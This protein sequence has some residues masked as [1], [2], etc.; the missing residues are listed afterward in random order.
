MDDNGSTITDTSGNNRNGTI[1]NAQRIPLGDKTLNFNLG[2]DSSDEKSVTL[3]DISTYSLGIDNLDIT[4]ENSLASLD[5]AIDNVSKIEAGYGANINTLQ[6]SLDNDS[7]QEIQTE[8]SNQRIEDAD[9]SKESSE[10]TKEEIK[11]S[12]TILM[13][14]KNETNRQQILSLLQG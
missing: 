4:Q 9:F 12:T 5:Q 10:L 2:G 1:Y 8:V 14:K 7:N 11:Q 6:F 3:K 13:I